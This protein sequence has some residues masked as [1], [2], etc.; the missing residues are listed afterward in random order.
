MST[1]EVNA[2]GAMAAM[3]VGD[4]ERSN[5]RRL[6]ILLQ[7]PKCSWQSRTVPKKFSRGRRGY[8]PAQKIPRT[9]EPYS[10]HSTVI[11]TE[12]RAE[13]IPV[14]TMVQIRDHNRSLI[15]P[16]MPSDINS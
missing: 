5:P 10:S 3:E 14:L 15:G 12:P 8:H 7:I 9:K 11:Q 2:E 16:S 13:A 1:C 4:K 6:V